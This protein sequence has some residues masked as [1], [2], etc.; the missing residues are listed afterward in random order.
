LALALAIALGLRAWWVATVDTQPVTDFGWYYD[1]AVSIASGLGYQVDGSPTAYWPVGYPAF[2]ALFFAAFGPSLGL[3]KALNVGLTVAVVGLSWLVARRLF[4]R[5]GVAHLTALLLAVHP[6]WVAYSSILASEPLFSVLVLAG[7]AFMLGHRRGSR[8]ALASAGLVFGLA[9][10]VRPQ[11]AALPALLLLCLAWR[12]RREA[13]RGEV[14]KAALWVYLPLILTLA[15]WTVRNWQVLGGFVFVSTN[16]GDNLLIGHHPASPG[17]YV[18]PTQLAPETAAMDEIERDRAA[19]RLAMR[20]VMADP[21]RSLRLA[22]PKLKA[23][24]LTG[25]DAPYWAFQTRPGGLV[26]PGMDEH[27]S[28]Y[29]WFSG[30]SKASPSVVLTLFLAGLLAGLLRFP[31]G[32]GP[33]PATPVAMVLATAALV[34]VFFGNP[35]FGLPALP[36]LLMVGSYPWAGL[37][38]RF[39]P[40]S[41]S[42]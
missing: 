4:A 19:R 15:P 42:S 34:C 24:F 31:K 2:L 27:R 35:R 18:R 29:L 38:E 22:G 8:T 11:G 28:L 30:V 13:F 26:T 3:A 37:A 33:L 40:G 23:T 41:R 6:A 7:T 10:L 17:T 39:I 16:G 25:T 14:W 21:V 5:E 12:D 9:T 20:A 32:G 1:R 36:F